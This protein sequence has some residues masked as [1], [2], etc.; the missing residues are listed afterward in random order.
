MEVNNREPNNG[1]VRNSKKV[2]V[3]SPQGGFKK[4]YNHRSWFVN[5]IYRHRTSLCN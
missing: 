4:Y 1:N 3:G 5:E 2:Y